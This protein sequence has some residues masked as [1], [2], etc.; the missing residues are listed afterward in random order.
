MLR[1]RRALTGALALAMAALAAATSPASAKGAG[2]G[3][4]IFRAAT[5]DVAGAFAV[6][7]IRERMPVLPRLARCPGICE[8]MPA[9]PPIQPMGIHPRLVA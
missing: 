4:P 8:R 7:G 3:F 6:A 2:Q 1:N 9:R 5:A